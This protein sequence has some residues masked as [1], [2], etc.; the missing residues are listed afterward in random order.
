MS[1]SRSERAS[2]TVCIGG[3]S[4]HKL[5]A[6]LRAAQVQLNPLALVLFE[7]T[8]FTT[9]EKIS[10]VET[11]ETSVAELGL[12]AGG[13]F[14]QILESAKLQ[15]LGLCPLELAPHL[16]LQFTEQPEGSVGYPASQN[17]APTG[18][19]TVASSALTED[20]DIPKGFYLRR[21]ERV[22]WLRGYISWAG[23]V[24]NP[25]D[26]FVFVRSKISV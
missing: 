21:I 16:R 11:V 13:T 14:E 22:L 24:W 2:R 17:R 4:K 23:H 25:E 15:E 10:I 18:T 19:L 5:L 3:A 20:D 9:A 12:Q 1:V 26:S 6:S 7:H 8:E